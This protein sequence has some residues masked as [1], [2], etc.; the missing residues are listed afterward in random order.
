VANGLRD[1]HKYSR[2]KAVIGPPITRLCKVEQVRNYPCMPMTTI[3]PDINPVPL[4]PIEIFPA[5]QFP[6]SYARILMAA[7]LF[8]SPGICTRGEFLPGRII[9]GK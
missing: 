1:R 5:I 6:G 3:N 2:Q 8:S 4:L 7:L 9:K